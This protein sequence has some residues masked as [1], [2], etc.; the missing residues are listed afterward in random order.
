[1]NMKTC[2]ASLVVVFATSGPLMSAT[3]TERLRALCEEQEMQIRQLEE[4]IARLTDTP[5]P[6]RPAPAAPAGARDFQPVSSEANYTVKSGD[7]IER[8]ARKNGMTPSSLA[9]LNGL[10]ADSL[11]HP[12]QKLKVPGETAVAGHESAPAPAEES[13]MHTVASGETFYKIAMKY[14]VTVDEL[15]AANPNVN[16]KA[17]Q[18]G[19]KIKVDRVAKSIVKAPAPAPALA[20]DAPVSILNDPAPVGKPRASDRPVRIEKEFTYGEFA[21]KHGTTTRRLDELNG[22]ELDP[23]T[24]LAQGSELYIP[25]QP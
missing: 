15:V 25:A 4:K 19:Q 12:G 11:I 10:K 13:R 18:V 23:S 7:S 9:K 6:S 14:A 2:L 8:I 16:H 1:M 3:E 22:L 5:P 20:S 24:V 17:L 21:A